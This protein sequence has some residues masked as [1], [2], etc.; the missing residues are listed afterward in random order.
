[1]SVKHVLFIGGIVFGLHFGYKRD[2]N[3]YNP[4]VTALKVRLREGEDI[5]RQYLR[6]FA[7]IH[8][9]SGW[10][11][12]RLFRTGHHISVHTEF[13]QTSFITSA[14]WI[15]NKLDA[16]N[17]ISPLSFR[18]FSD[19]SLSFPKLNLFCIGASM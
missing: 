16:C 1:M 11:C 19:A 14:N 3:V 2:V 9:R 8:S 7:V 15:P 4:K 5:Y 6:S 10:R 18:M 17:D 13:M 12:S